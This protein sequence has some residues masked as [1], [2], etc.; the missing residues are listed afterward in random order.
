MRAQG[1]LAIAALRLRAPK[2]VTKRHAGWL[3]ETAEVPQIPDVFAAAPK[4]VSLVPFTA[5]SKCSNSA[6]WTIV[7]STTS[8]ARNMIDSG[9]VRPSVFAV[10]RLI[11]NSN[12]VGC[13]TGKSVGCA[14]LR[15]RPA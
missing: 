14:P 1:A 2:W 9:I 5:V 12:L 4:G 11:T 8:S 3:T 13:M 7:Y 6:L 15:M 10:V